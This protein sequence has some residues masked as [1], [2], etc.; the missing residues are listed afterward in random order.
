MK[1]PPLYG[2]QIVSSMKKKILQ[3]KKLLQEAGK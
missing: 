2:L 3:E 1:L